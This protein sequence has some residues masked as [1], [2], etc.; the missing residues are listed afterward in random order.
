MR[1]GASIVWRWRETPHADRF[2]TLCSWRPI[3]YQQRD[4]QGRLQKHA[5]LPN[6]TFQKEVSM[7]RLFRLLRRRGQWDAGIAIHFVDDMALFRNVLGIPL[8]KHRLS[9]KNAE[10]HQKILRSFN[11]TPHGRDDRI[12]T[13]G[14]LVPN[15]AL[16]QTELHPD[17][18]VSFRRQLFYYSL[19]STACQDFAVKSLKKRG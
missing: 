13:C 5:S 9:I 8:I 14:I 16:Y 4:Q 1:C 12:R 2:G 6:G 19:G 7:S 11:D 3:S 10:Y 17:N 15:Q 18:A